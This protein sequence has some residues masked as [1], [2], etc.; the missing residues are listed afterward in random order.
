[1]ADG[2]RLFDSFCDRVGD[3]VCYSVLLLGLEL[4]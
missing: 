3:D 2:S 4:V 1:M